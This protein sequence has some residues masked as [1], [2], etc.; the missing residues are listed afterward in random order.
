MKINPLVSETKVS[1][2]VC[3]DNPPPKR[4]L[5]QFYQFNTV[6]KSSI[7]VLHVFIRL[8]IESDER[9]TFSCPALSKRKIRQK[10][11]QGQTLCTPS[12]SRHSMS[13]LLYF[14]WFACKTS[15]KLIWI[16]FNF[17]SILTFVDDE[18]QID[19]NRN[20]R[21]RFVNPQNDF[22]QTLFIPG[23]ARYLA[24]WSSRPGSYVYT[25][26]LIWFRLCCKRYV[27]CCVDS[28]V[29]L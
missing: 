18:I 19:W 9:N 1:N 12:L 7:E 20:K 8:D 13:M 6:T 5:I 21:R 25:I 16:W 3:N 29:P 28:F 11:R 17:P 4:V 24:I 14:N 22:V 27:A 23:Y 26:L 15:P 2:V 10:V